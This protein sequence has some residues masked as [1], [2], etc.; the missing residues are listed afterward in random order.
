MLTAR[1][2]DYLWHTGRELQAR[3]EE[4]QIELI[5]WS[6]PRG[7]RGELRKIDT[8][9]RKGMSE[10]LN[11]TVSLGQCPAD[12]RRPNRES[13]RADVACEAK[14]PER[15][16]RAAAEVKKVNPDLA[17]KVRYGATPLA[18]SIGEGEGN[19]ESL[20][21]SDGTSLSISASFV[22]RG[23]SDASLAQPLKKRRLV[24]N[25]MY[26]REP[27]PCMEENQLGRRNLSDDQR[28][29]V[30]GAR[31]RRSKLIVI[32]KLQRARDVKAGSP[33]SVSVSDIERPKRDTHARGRRRRGQ[34]PRTQAT[35]RRSET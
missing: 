5:R 26:R 33:M 27:E 30:E 3:W 23:E 28:A 32:E 17:Q 34:N 11:R 8:L 10:T 2:D 31:E 16:P 19:G 9:T 21:Q 22:P 7:L 4:G 6:W 14:I 13:T 12:A 24:S 1:V 18:A 20:G 35:R 15:K 29:M 25:E